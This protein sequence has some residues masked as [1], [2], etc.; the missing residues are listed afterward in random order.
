MLTAPVP[1]ADAFISDSVRSVAFG[2]DGILA[3]GVYNG[4]TYSDAS[5][6]YLWNTTTGKVTASRIQGDPS[7]RAR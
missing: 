3:T 6:T 5:T 1:A 4:S 2:P 7:L